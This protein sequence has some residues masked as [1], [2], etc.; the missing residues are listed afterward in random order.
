[1][2]K[3]HSKFTQ[4]YSKQIR[5]SQISF[6][7]GCQS[8]RKNHIVCAFANRPFVFFHNCTMLA[9]LAFLY[10]SS[11]GDNDFS[12]TFTFSGGWTWDIGTVASLVFTL[13]CLPNLRRDNWVTLKADLSWHTV[14]VFKCQF[15][16]RIIKPYKD[17][18]RC[19]LNI[20]NYGM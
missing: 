8:I 6:F 19:N 3:I 15:K 7:F 10:W 4:I 9:M 17:S 16:Q 18:C 2:N 14:R 11:E 12:K 5:N 20:C 13:S 1:M